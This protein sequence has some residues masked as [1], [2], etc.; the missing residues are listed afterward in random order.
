M[1]E[2]LRPTA[3]RTRELAVGG[4]SVVMETLV[5]VPLLDELPRVSAGTVLPYGDV[6]AVSRA[7]PVES[8]LMVNGTATGAWSVPKSR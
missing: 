6:S 5:P 1:V 7:T 2:E 4:G 8:Q 3:S